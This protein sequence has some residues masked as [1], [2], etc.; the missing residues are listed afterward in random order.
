MERLDRLD[1]KQPPFD[2]TDLLCDL[3][4]RISGRAGQHGTPICAQV[5]MKC[6]YG[7]NHYLTDMHLQTI[8]ALRLSAFAAN[9]GFIN[10]RRDVR[11][12]IGDAAIETS[13]VIPLFFTIA[14]AP[15]A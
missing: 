2:L 8:S 9:F 5:M 14:A 13:P 6:R 10:R 1:L 11:C 4:H 3:H 15:S 12:V 7:M